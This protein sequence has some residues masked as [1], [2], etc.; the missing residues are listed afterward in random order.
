VESKDEWMVNKLGHSGK[1]AHWSILVLLLLMGFILGTVIGEVLSPFIPIL[2]K[3]A[4]AGINTQTFHLAKTFSLTFG[5]HVQLNLATVVG[6]IIAF[7][8]YRRL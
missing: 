1:T 5:F 7:V 6:V 3:G 8:I 4:S 2:A